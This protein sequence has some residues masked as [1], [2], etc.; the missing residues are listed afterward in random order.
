MT[1]ARLAYLGLA[2]VAV[3]RV[4]AACGDSEGTG[5]SRTDVES[6]PSDAHD[7]DLPGADANVVLPSFCTGIVLYASFDDGAAPQLGA[8]EPRLLGTARQLPAGR[9]GGGL[10]LVGDVSDDDGAALYFVRPDGG[11]PVFPEHE[12]SLAMWIRGNITEG[13]PVYYRPVGSLPPDTLVSAGLSLVTT[14]GRF[15]LAS[16]QPGL[17]MELIHA[18]P[19]ASVRPYVRQDDFNHV[20][21][22]WRRGDAAGPTAY[23]TINGGQG[24]RFS[25]DAS[26]DAADPFADAG[27]DD[28]GTLAI[29]YRGYT[30]THWDHDASAVA[31]RLGA[32]NLLNA[33]DATIDDTAVWDRVLS[34][35]EVAAVYKA[36]VSIREACHLP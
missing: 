5:P 29:P 20:A 26:A 15:G 24:E 28:A 1:I 7:S 19:V 25:K 35:D 14:G 30:S 12:G 2:C 34:F 33:P 21:T 3:I 23:L 31:L 9:F 13:Q 32:P 4:I 8:G 18:F 27:P 10:G 11:Q 22:S 17:P 16:S 6:N 36:G